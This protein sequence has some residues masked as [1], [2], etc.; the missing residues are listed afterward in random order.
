M[1]SR[2]FEHE[3]PQ[4]DP[5][6][7]TDFWD[8]DYSS[9]QQQ[10]K[11]P[12]NI[13]N[14]TAYDTDD[15]YN[16][17]PIPTVRHEAPERQHRLSRRA[18]ALVTTAV[19]TIVAA[20][21]AAVVTHKEAGHEKA[22]A[23]APRAP[24]QPDQE[25]LP[26]IN[27][28]AVAYLESFEGNATTEHAHFNP[29][30]EARI[31]IDKAAESTDAPNVVELYD[32]MFGGRDPQSLK[33]GELLQSIQTTQDELEKAKAELTFPSLPAN[34]HKLIADAESGESSIDFGVYLAAAKELFGQH[35]ADVAFAKVNKHATEITPERIATV[36]FT[37]QQNKSDFEGNSEIR[38]RLTREML[39]LSKVNIGNPVLENFK[40]LKF[41]PFHENM[42]TVG[43]YT[44]HVTPT[45]IYYNTRELFP[46]PVKL[47][48]IHSG[49]VFHEGDHLNGN[50]T[51]DSLAASLPDGFTYGDATYKALESGKKVNGMT[52]M[53]PDPPESDTPES[54][55]KV[56][57][58]RPYSIVSPKEQASDMVQKILS[59]PETIY[60]SIG[61]VTA[62]GVQAA[63]V[64]E[65]L[66]QR[67]PK[68]AAYITAKLKLIRLDLALT[69]RM[70]HA[71]PLSDVNGP[72]AA[73]YVADMQARNRELLDT[74]AA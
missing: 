13:S 29:T 46:P 53:E 50:P 74:D 14:D 3:D 73:Q 71:E 18:A 68:F 19:L 9:P 58:L 39:L 11:H 48:T 1:P 63:I 5:Y 26:S 70:N 55:D 36:P 32:Q 56:G 47:S 30:Q 49:L 24:S 20:G 51:A 31:T 57:F 62:I 67:D 44:T 6:A 15:W 64:I 60:S 38:A 43:G 27:P 7:D 35:G 40:H 52:S 33:A 21:G 37:E 66:Q 25:V 59:S 10:D 42:G 16:N 8:D 17:T 23:S 28:D 12:S 61:D 34:F 72:P 45:T 41:G 69:G 4:G 65:N 54:S 22:T 2:N